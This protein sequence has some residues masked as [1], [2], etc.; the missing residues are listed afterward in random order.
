MTTVNKIMHGGRALVSVG[1]QLVGIITDLSWQVSYD[2]QEAYI[3]GRM[4]PAEIAYTAQEPISGSITAWRVV[5]HGVHASLGLPRLDQLLTADYTEIT[6]FDRGMQKIIGEI[7]QCRLG[8]H[9]EGTSVRQFSQANIPF[10]AILFSDET[11]QNN[12]E[13]ADRADLP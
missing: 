5:D 8:G 12:D 3:L 7:Q 13:R 2:M 6:L 11:A 1:G 9:G 10:K 4:H